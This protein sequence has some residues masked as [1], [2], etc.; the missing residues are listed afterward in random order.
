[1]AARAKTVWFDPNVAA[2]GDG[3]EGVPNHHFVAVNKDGLVGAI[4]RQFILRFSKN[5]K[6]IPSRA[7][8]QAPAQF[9]PIGAENAH[10]VPG[11][12]APSDSEDTDGQYTLS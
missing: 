1:L 10:G 3:L 2:F 12:K 11:G 8:S 7:P 9:D 4:G 6:G 5:A